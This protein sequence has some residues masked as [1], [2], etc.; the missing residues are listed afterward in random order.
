MKALE[1][2]LYVTDLGEATAFYSRL[3]N[4]QPRDLLPGRHAFFQLD[5]S[6][7][8]LFNAEQTRQVTDLPIPTHGS[9]GQGHFCLSSAPKGIDHWRQ[10][11]AELGI[12]LEIEFLWPNGARSLYFRDPSGNSLEIA[13]PKLWGFND[14]G[15]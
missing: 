13:E 12:Q 7:L 14:D 10:R 11:L 1:S 8:L 4:Q 5:G 15:I 6:V 9:E 3:L 2:A